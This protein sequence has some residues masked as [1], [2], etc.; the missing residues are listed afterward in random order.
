MTA[1]PAE[2]M[3]LPYVKA[4]VESIPSPIFELAADDAVAPRPGRKLRRRLR[5]IGTP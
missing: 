2:R 1:S 4:I 3:H 5:R